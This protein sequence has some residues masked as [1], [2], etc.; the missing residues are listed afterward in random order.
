MN[1]TAHAYPEQESPLALERS[2]LGHAMPRVNLEDFSPLA[3]VYSTVNDLLKFLSAK[4][5]WFMSPVQL[6]QSSG[7]F[8]LVF[9]WDSSH[10]AGSLMAL[11]GE[12]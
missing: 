7:S 12:R 5:A 1:D 8:Q 10:R 3:G 9:V 11:R 4:S 2:K 6:R